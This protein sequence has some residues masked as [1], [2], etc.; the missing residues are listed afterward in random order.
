MC[1]PLISLF[2]PS[3]LGDV[4]LENDNFADA[5]ADIEKAI[6]LET[7]QRVHSRRRYVEGGGGAC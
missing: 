3:C 4:N 5:R 7:T 1:R 6:A 2:A